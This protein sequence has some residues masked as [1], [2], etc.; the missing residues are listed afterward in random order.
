MDRWRIR[1]GT[2]IA[3]LLL[4]LTCG[5]CD[6]IDSVVLH[7]KTTV[8]ASTEKHTGILDTEN[9]GYLITKDGNTI[10]VVSTC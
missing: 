6:V 8:V 4:I 7:I 2:A 5:Y 3:M 1:L 10:H 9:R